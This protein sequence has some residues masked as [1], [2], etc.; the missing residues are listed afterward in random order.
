MTKEPYFYFYCGASTAPLRS[1]G[2]LDHFSRLFAGPSDG[3]RKLPF[4]NKNFADTKDLDVII[5]PTYSRDSRKIRTILRIRHHED[6]DVHKDFVGDPFSRGMISIIPSLWGL[7]PATIRQPINPYDP[8]ILLNEEPEFSHFNLD[9]SMDGEFLT[10]RDPVDSSR[11]KVGRRVLLCPE[12]TNGQSVHLGKH[13]EVTGAGNREPEDSVDSLLITETVR[14]GNRILLRAGEIFKAPYFILDVTYDR[15]SLKNRVSQLF[16]P[17]KDPDESE[18]GLIESINRL[19][20]TIRARNKAYNDLERVNAELLDSKKRVDEYA[21]TLEQK[22]EERTA[23]L[24]SAKEELILF[25]RNLEAK[26]NMQVEELR[27]L[28]ELRRYLSPR[29]AEKIL[30]TGGLLGTEPQRKMMTVLFADIR[31]FSS[32][33]ETLE[34]EELFQL[35]HKYLSEM[36]RIIHEYEGTLNK[37]I[38]DGLLVFFGDP[39]PMSDHAERAVKT[40]MEMQTKVTELRSEWRRYGQELGI[41]IGINTGY[42]TVGNICNPLK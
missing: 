42:M 34:P 23:E 14:A 17:R 31:N 3:F 16:R 22:V 18:K 32:F 28:D 29:L 37:I 1:W 24:R 40:A 11:R 20:E 27:N 15:F 8:E 10:I 38:G 35:L 21:K 5:P 9:A 33:T 30:S 26:V 25:N 12:Q 19:R 7:R 4:F 6:I 36:T 13:K 2:R 41:G 39:I